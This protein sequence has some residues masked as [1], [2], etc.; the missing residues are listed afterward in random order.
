M[1]KA[2]HVIVVGAGVA[3]L[4]S[5]IRM[6]AMGYDVT[7]FDQ[8]PKVGGKLAQCTIDG[9]R[10]DMGPSL[11]TMPQ[12]IEELFELSSKDIS[13]YF[14]YHKEKEIC[15]YQF[16]DGSVFK[17]PA[18]QEK[19][20]QQ[21]A[22]TF[23]ESAKVLRAYLR[24]NAF[25]YNKTKRIFLEKSLHKWR[26]FLHVDTLKGI[27]AMPQLDMLGSLHALNQKTFSDS[28]LVQLFDRY[29]TYNGSTP[30]RAPGIM[31]L[32]SHL[33]MDLGTFFPKGGMISI[34][35]A[36][37]RL[38]V[39]NGVRFELNQRVDQILTSEK[40][41]GGV[42]IGEQ[43]IAADI[44]VCN[45]DIHFAFKHL[46]PQLKAP[47]AVMQQE[48]SSSG[49]IFYWCMDAS[50]PDLQLH[51]IFFA[52]DYKKEFDWIAEGGEWHNDPTVYINITSKKEQGDAP[53]GKENWF[54]MVNVPAKKDQDWNKWTAI[55]KEAVLAKLNKALG[56]DVAAFIVGEQVLTPQLIEQRTSSYLGALYGSASND[57]L[58]AFLRHPNFHSSVEGLYFCGGSVH[59]GGGIPLCLLSAKIVADLIQSEHA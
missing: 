33:E 13:A 5:A 22:S 7:V 17:A 24:K 1:S 53:A 35:N 29:A 10:F 57:R 2:K 6:R 36:L 19:F 4:A 56:R 37:H 11:F 34:P 43:V 31:S 51:N 55:V 3:G 52:N 27:A 49:I 44:V 59:P 42:R 21:A 46:L 58:A 8:N 54:V 26:S 15:R 23:G 41:V 28:R 47:A 50:F 39:D 25:K 32:I 18:D 20:I 38:A 45:A 40:N 30:Y 14:Q 12:F 48:R 16:H 9:F